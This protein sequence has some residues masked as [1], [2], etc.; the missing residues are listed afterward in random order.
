[1]AADG[2][3][4][5]QGGAWILAGVDRDGA[6][7]AHARARLRRESAARVTGPDACRRERVHATQRSRQ[8]SRN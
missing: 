7:H 8:R 5:P 6:A 4:R 3:P 2:G 1:M